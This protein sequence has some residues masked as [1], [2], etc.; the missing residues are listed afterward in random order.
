M[1]VPAEAKALNQKIKWRWRKRRVQWWNRKIQASDQKLDCQKNNISSLF[2]PPK[3]REWMKCYY[4]FWYSEGMKWHHET[5][6]PGDLS[7]CLSLSL[8]TLTPT[9]SSCHTQ[10][11]TCSQ[12]RQSQPRLLLIQW[13]EPPGWFC[14]DCVLPNATPTRRGTSFRTSLLR[15]DDVFVS[16]RGENQERG[17]R[18]R[19]YAW[20]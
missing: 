10:M 7:S 18:G 20:F 1:L 4:S 19:V 2:V 14:K 5:S 8:L 11:S 15:R 9:C 17:K 16:L 13:Q 6:L 3:I 12:Q